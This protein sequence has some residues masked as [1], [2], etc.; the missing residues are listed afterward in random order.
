M[1]AVTVVGRGKAA[2]ALGC[3]ARLIKSFLALRLPN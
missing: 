2:G 1:H 3:T